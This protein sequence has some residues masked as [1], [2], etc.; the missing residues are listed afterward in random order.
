[1]KVLVEPEPLEL[2]LPDDGFAAEDS[3]DFDTDCREDIPLESRMGSYCLRERSGA[4]ASLMHFMQLAE[5]A[6]VPPEELKRRATALLVSAAED[7]LRT[8]NREQTK[9]PPVGKVQIR[10]GEHEYLFRIAVLFSVERFDGEELVSLPESR[11]LRL[12]T[13]YRQLLKRLVP[14]TSE[15]AALRHLLTIAAAKAVDEGKQS[16]RF[17]WSLRENGE[18]KRRMPIDFVVDTTRWFEYTD[19]DPLPIFGP[20]PEIT[21]DPGEMAVESTAAV[22]PSTEK[23]PQ[24]ADISV[25]GLKPSA[26]TWNVKKSLACRSILAAAILIPTLYMLWRFFSD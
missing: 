15:R 18:S 14:E 17:K 4:M 7:A 5:E 6:E 25:P 24:P 10:V 9:E 12:K 22:I 16:F 20:D 11:R 13:P 2:D 23:E 19:G 1:M 26:E 21:A 3:P 8:L